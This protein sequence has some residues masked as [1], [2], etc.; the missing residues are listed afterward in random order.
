MPTVRTPAGTRI[1]IQSAIA[2]SQSVT[3]I[4]KANPGVV[5]YAGNDPAPGNYVALSNI[6]G[7]TELEDA[8]VRVGT[9]DT[10]G[11]TFQLED[12]DTT[13]YGTFVS[14]AMQVVTLG[15]EIQV[16]TGFSITGGEQQFAE[17]TYL[18]DKI[19]RRF[20][21]SKS[22]MTIE[23]PMIWDPQD[24]GSV[25]LLAASDAS[26]KTGFK[27]VFADGLEMLFFGY[28]GSSGMPNANDINSVMQTNATIVTA[29]RVR[30]AF[31]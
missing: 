4:T 11:N 10:T 25:A 30:Y 28:L 19:T 31:P 5:S 13:A 21:T 7:M 29:S 2:A 23:L 22:G 8:L 3:A 12:Q 27:I 16:A 18:W 17:Y 1:Y 20:P 14:G 6:Q 24:A 26:R 15:T 9:V